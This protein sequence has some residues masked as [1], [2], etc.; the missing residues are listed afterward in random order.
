ML[1]AQVCLFLGGVGGRTWKV[2]HTQV[3]LASVS[4]SRRFNITDISLHFLF[5]Y[6]NATCWRIY[7]LRRQILSGCRANHFISLV[8]VSSSG[9]E[10]LLDMVSVDYIVCCEQLSHRRVWGRVMS[11]SAWATGHIFCFNYHFVLSSKPRIGFTLIF[12]SVIRISPYLP[13]PGFSCNAM[14]QPTFFFKVS[15]SSPECSLRLLDS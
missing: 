4:V 6:G 11:Y 1:T 2:S 10:E 15:H 14:W 9:Q 5:E 7:L 13:T 8:S 3:F 12:R